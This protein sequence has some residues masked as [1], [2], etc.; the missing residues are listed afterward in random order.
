MGF[1]ALFTEKCFSGGDGEE[2]KGQYWRENGK[3]RC[4]CTY[5]YKA[6]SGAMRRRVCMALTSQMKDGCLCCLGNVKRHTTAADV[7]Y[8]W[9]QIL[10]L[11]VN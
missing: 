3:M 4:R 6:S 5:M 7:V 11:H 10:H 9:E 1:A 2:K 8:R